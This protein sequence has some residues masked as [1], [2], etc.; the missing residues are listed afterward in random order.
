MVRTAPP[1][2]WTG[3]TTWEAAMSEHARAT[4]AGE[5]D[6]PPGTDDP[7][8]PTPRPGPEQ[9]PSTPPSPG[10]PGAPTPPPTPGPAGP[11]IDT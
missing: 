9:P 11:D 4:A 8:P 1:G 2:E 3:E 7:V 6:V 10:P 5:I